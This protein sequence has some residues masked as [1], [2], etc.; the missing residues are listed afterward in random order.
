MFERA[1]SRQPRRSRSQPRGPLGCTPTLQPPWEATWASTLSQQSQ[2]LAGQVC[3]TPSDARPG[4]RMDRT[5]QDTGGRMRRICK[6][7]VAGSI[8]ARSTPGRSPAP[9]ARSHD[10]F[11]RIAFS[12]G[13]RERPTP[14]KPASAA[15]ASGGPTCG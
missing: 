14:A 9:L 15:E 10:D 4:T 7:E 11:D 3:P 6:P 13:D 2:Q 12:P 8:P 5:G 1:G